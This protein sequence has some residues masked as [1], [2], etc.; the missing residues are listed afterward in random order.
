MV[1]DKVVALGS[2]KEDMLHLSDMIKSNAG[3]YNAAV[4]SNNIDAST[5]IQR[6]YTDFKHN[7]FTSTLSTKP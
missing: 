1:G 3:N 5:T 2:G 6:Y 4:S 7:N